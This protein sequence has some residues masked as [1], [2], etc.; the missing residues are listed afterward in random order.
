MYVDGVA[1]TNLSGNSVYAGG[2]ADNDPTTGVNDPY[3]IDRNSPAIGS[4][5]YSGFSRSYSLVGKIRNLRV[6]KGTA[7]WSSN[8]TPPLAPLSN[9]S[10]TILLLLS[11]NATNATYDSSNYHWSPSAAE[12]GF[13][14]PTYLAP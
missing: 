11:Q 10:G 1:I 12:S 13:F 8:F 5:A 2:G 9:Q 7:L 4:L 3:N 14:L 6:I